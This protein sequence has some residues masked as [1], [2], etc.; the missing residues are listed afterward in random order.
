MRNYQKKK[1]STNLAKLCSKKAISKNSKKIM[2]SPKSCLF[3][4]VF[5]LSICQ[6]LA[7]LWQFSQKIHD[8]KKIFFFKIFFS[9]FWKSLFLSIIWRDLKKKFFWKFQKN[10][11]ENFS[12]WKKCNFGHYFQ[13][14]T[15]FTHT[16]NLSMVLLSC[17]LKNFLS[18]MHTH[19]A[20]EHQSIQKR[21]SVV[22]YPV[23]AKGCCCFF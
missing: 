16:N 13:F 4:T 1:I 7:I 5:I 21:Q 11:F 19:W 12:F 15:G 3:G 14:L 9:N 6:F 2:E 8:Q 23:F 10:Y 22:R 20:P 17:L 18:D